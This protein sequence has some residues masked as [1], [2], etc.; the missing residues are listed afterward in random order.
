MNRCIDV[1]GMDPV[2]S[3]S[4]ICDNFR[5]NNLITTVTDSLE[6]AQYIK[7]MAETTGI[8]S[9]LEEMG[10]DFYVHLTNNTRLQGYDDCYS[11][12]KAVIV[13]TGDTLG[14]GD[15]K[16]GK[17]LLEAYIY[18]L[19]YVH[20]LPKSIIFMNKGIFLSVEGS[21]CLD[22]LKSLENRGVTIL[23]SS[24]CLGYYNK[25]DS[26]DVGQQADMN[27]IVRIINKSQRV[28]VI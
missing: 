21:N 12:S 16:L 3:W 25:K 1:R 8:D 18:Q 13:I 24:I 7:D 2:K 22:N 26:L 20:P 19:Q 5:S 9:C 17:I 23:S 28:I 11:S 4:M 15:E 10:G 6:A 14:R 27:E